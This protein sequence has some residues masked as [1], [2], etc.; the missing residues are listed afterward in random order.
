MRDDPADLPATPAEGGE[1]DPA[2]LAA[3]VGSRICHDLISPIGAIGNGVELLALE[4]RAGS[5]EVMLIADSVAQADARVR[6]FRIAFGAASP[7]QRIAQGEVQ[8]VLAD[9]TRGG[10]VRIGWQSPGDL[11]RAEVRMAFLA[12]MAC[13]SALPFGGRIEVALTGGAWQ[14]TG[15]GARLRLDPPLWSRLGAPRAAGPLPA[16][17]H[18]HFALLPIAVTAGGRALAVE[19]TPTTVRLAF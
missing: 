13:E 8:R 7:G 3:L 12:V 9:V 10:K 4:T 5:P 11:A 2:A 15:E 17:A 19:T 6:F 16:P 14:V 18:V 1:D